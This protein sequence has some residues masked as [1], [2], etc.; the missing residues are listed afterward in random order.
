M[1]LLKKNSES[2]FKIELRLLFQNTFLVKER[3]LNDKHLQAISW[4]ELSNDFNFPKWYYDGKVTIQLN[5]SDELKTNEDIVK[6]LF[7]LGI[8]GTKKS[9]INDTIPL[10]V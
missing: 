10:S 6:Y 3:F 5:N 4:C 8:T 9:Q 1:A 7:N 2:K